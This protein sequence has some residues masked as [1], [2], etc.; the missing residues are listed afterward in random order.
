MTMVPR[1]ILMGEILPNK[2][3]FRVLRQSL[4]NIG[5][6]PGVRPIM[7]TFFVGAMFEKSMSQLMRCNPE[8][9]CRGQMS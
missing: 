6:L 9:F 2:A 1:V 5:Y 7:D 8:L 3:V 4:W